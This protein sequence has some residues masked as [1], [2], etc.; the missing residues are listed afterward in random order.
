MATLSRVR[1]RQRNTHCHKDP[2]M[3]AKTVAAGIAEDHH[4][5]HLRIDPHAIVD[6]TASIH[7]SAYVDQDVTIGAGTCIWHFSH[8][9]PDSHVGDRCRIGQNV[10]IGPRVTIGNNVKIQN[11][12]SVYEGVTLED[13][14]FCGPS[15]V[16]TNIATPRSAFPRN[17][18]EDNLPT[19]VC[20]GAS[21]GANA[22]VICGCTIGEHALVGAGAVITRD[23][24][25]HA[26]VY[27]NPARQHGWACVCGA[28]LDDAAG[29]EVACAE[30][31][32]TYRLSA[33][34]CEPCE[35]ACSSVV[36]NTHATPPHH[37]IPV[38]DVRPQYAQLKDEIDAVMKDVAAAGNFI[39][40]PNVKAFEQE[41][42]AYC[43]CSHAVGVANG[44]DALH[45]ALR[46]LSIGPGDEVI[47]TPFTFVAT[48]EAI[49]MVGATPVFVDIDLRTFNIDHRL[50]EEAITPR[51]KAILPVHLY[52]R[53]CAMDEIMAIAHRHGLKVVEDCAQALGATYR[54]RKIGTFGDVG[55]LSFFPS[56]NLGC[57][58]DGGMV[59]TNDA[60]VFERVEMLRRH[61]GRVKYH[62]E[63]LGMNSRLDELQAAILRVKLPHLDRWNAARRR[64]ATAYGRSLNGLARIQLPLPP[65]PALGHVFHQYTIAIDDRDAASDALRTAGIGTA[66][67]Y[68]TPL[69]LQ[70]VHAQLNYR[71][72]DLPKA[73][74]AAARVLSLP[75]Y[76]GMPEEVILR[77]AE[78]IGR[79][80]AFTVDI[81]TPSAA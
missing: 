18:P 20:R 15:M 37:D 78:V 14:V 63:E 70:P 35:K 74:A 16:F 45:L 12:V 40:G 60:A 28:V 50:I 43:G 69:H 33:Q 5:G 6:D 52:G 58:G 32:R 26:V 39:L 44:T 11:N 65:D 62:H 2:A 34:S 73:E 23:V 13:D 49:L 36:F 81:Y 57:M 29:E 17:R 47:T 71:R 76:P 72:G 19:R 1:H 3:P 9:L 27:G 8:V 67:Y 64:T 51:T 7:E 22:T 55:C 46:A 10:V 48:T 59:L 25:A 21:I 30:C 68:P 54:G 61:G 24:P 4:A 80:A 41:M 53:P 79:Q 66:V 56:K 77:V 75:M 31:G 42:A 38:C